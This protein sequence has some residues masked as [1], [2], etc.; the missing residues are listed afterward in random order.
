LSVGGEDFHRFIHENKRLMLTTFESLQPASCTIK[1]GV[2]VAT[3]TTRLMTVEEFEK[4]PNPP[5]GVYELF[6][7]QP[8]TVSYPKNPHVQAQWQLRQLLQAAAGASGRVYTEFPYRP[9]PEYECWGADVAYLPKARWT[10]IEDWLFGAPDLVVEVLSPSNTKA[11]L[12]DKRKIC[13][14]TGTVEFWVVDTDLREVEVYT[15]GA[16]GITY[17][18]GQEIPLFFVK[19]PGGSRLA[20]DEIFS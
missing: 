4:L 9:L 18:A 15:S 12:H 14:E 17:K 6:H 1:P 11:R 19:S 8:V 2:P 7:G 16:S 13:L 20:V 10:R 5:D 3:T